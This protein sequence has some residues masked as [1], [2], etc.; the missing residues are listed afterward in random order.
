[1]EYSRPKSLSPLD[2]SG[3]RDWN[4]SRV[5]WVRKWYFRV[6]EG[7]AVVAVSE[8]ALG[9]KVVRCKGEFWFASCG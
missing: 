7:G 8:E 1:M 4:T 6:S 5:A 9:G 3:S 2:F